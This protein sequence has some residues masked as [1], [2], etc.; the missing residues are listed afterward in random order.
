MISTKMR[1]QC[2]NCGK[3]ARSEDCDLR[4]HRVSGIRRWFHRKGLKAN[5]VFGW[6]KEEDWELV[7]RELGET[8]YEEAMSIGSAVLHIEDNKN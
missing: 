7:D 5:C 2:F 6:H 1:V 4:R 3:W 8:T